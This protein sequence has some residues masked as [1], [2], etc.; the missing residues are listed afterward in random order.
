MTTLRV[1]FLADS[2][3]GLYASFSGMTEEQVARY[4]DLGMH[5]LPSP[6]TKGHEWD[7]RQ[8]EKAV[9]AANRLRPDL[10]LF[11]GDM[12]DDP[13]SDE[14]IDDFM[15]ITARLDPEIP[16]RF[17]PG[18]HDIAVDTV[19]P[20]PESIAAYRAVYGDDYYRFDLG[21]ASFLVLDTVVI[22]HP[23]NVPGELEAQLA[24]VKDALTGG[25]PPI[26]VGHHPFFVDDVHEADTSWNLPS[27]RRVPL[28]ERMQGA[29]VRLSIAGH[30]HRNNIARAG[31]LEMVT[32][33]PVG[34]PLGDDPSGF[35]VVDIAADGSISHRYLALDPD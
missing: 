2:Q 11:G 12:I 17:A 23:E 33:G 30:W 31:D 3:L 19:V 34:Y 5:I 22:D 32:S 6:P 26:V 24:V 16:V 4:A 7:A 1:L 15:A 35:R 9:V 25:R 29:G 21:P 18:N 13:N 27:E 10:V 20:T 14:Q 8:Y 28:I